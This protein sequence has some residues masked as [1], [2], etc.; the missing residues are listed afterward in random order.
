MANL[1]QKAIESLTEA[2]EKG[3]GCA[4]QEQFAAIPR[5]QHVAAVNAMK[6]LHQQHVIAR[7]AFDNLEFHVKE[8]GWP[9]INLPKELSIGIYKKY[10][11]LH[12]VK[13]P[14]FE[15]AVDPPGPALCE[16]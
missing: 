6:T 14:L 11:G 15:E 12:D 3:H 5:E 10:F 13:K 4:L 2:A 7:K 8:S 1:D 16:D 9:L